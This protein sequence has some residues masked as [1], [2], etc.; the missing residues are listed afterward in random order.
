[1]MI[2]RMATGGV[3]LSKPF[4]A[5]EKG[6]DGKSGGEGVDGNGSEGVDSLPLHGFAIYWRDL[7]FSVFRWWGVTG[8]AHDL[9]RKPAIRVEINASRPDAMTTNPT[10][11]PI[12]NDE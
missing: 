8:T 7:S 11:A 6:D 9:L 2:M 3:I 10:A 4:V 1:M 12:H 5:S